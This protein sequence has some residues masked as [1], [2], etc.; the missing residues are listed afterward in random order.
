[1]KVYLFGGK[2]MSFDHKNRVVQ[3][4]E[5]IHGDKRRI[6]SIVTINERTAQI[7]AQEWAR[8]QGI[9]INELDLYG[10]NPTVSVDDARGVLAMRMCKAIDPNEDLMLLL[11]PLTDWH[12]PGLSAKGKESGF[13]VLPIEI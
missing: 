5:N 8:N 1:M 3:V 12:M 7:F 2:P 4:L 9:E 10:I 11:P 6:D 13:E